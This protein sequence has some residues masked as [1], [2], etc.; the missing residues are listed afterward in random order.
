MRINWYLVMGLLFIIIL[1]VFL[2]TMGWFVWK[3]VIQPKVSS[4]VKVMEIER[5]FYV[6]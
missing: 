1:Y 3:N 5:S 2:A 4:T 6:N